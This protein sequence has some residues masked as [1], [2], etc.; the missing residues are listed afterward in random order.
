MTQ[1]ETPMTLADVCAY[2]RCSPRT[3]RRIPKD[4]LPWTKPGSERLY[5]PS[6]L[7]QYMLAEKKPKEPKPCGS[8]RRNARRTG[9][10]AGTPRTDRGGSFQNRLAKWQSEQQKRAAQN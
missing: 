7:A 2:L 3:V 1:L 6:A 9:K 10:P 4:A 8:S 5:L